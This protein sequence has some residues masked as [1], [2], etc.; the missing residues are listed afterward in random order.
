MSR[1]DA[2]NWTW[3][4]SGDEVFPAMLAAIGQARQSICLESYMYAAGQLG[5]AFREALIAA[6]QRG[7]NVRVLVDAIGSLELPDSYLEPLRAVGGEVRVF[8][9]LA[10]RRMSIRDH[11]KL[12]VCDQSVAFVGGFNISDDYQGDGIERGWRDVGARFEGGLV[13][14][15][16][17]SF[18][19]MFALAD[20]LHKRPVRLQ[21]ARQK[22]VVS[23]ANVQLLLSG[24]G[25]GR[26][27]IRRALLADLRRARRVQIAVPYFIPSWGLRRQLA[28]AARRGG[29]VQLLLP[30]KCDVTLAQLA[31]R[32]LYRGLLRAGVEIYEYQPQVLHAKLYVLD[33][34]V[35]VGSSNLDPRSLTINYEL[36]VRRQDASEAARAREIF[37]DSLAH[38]RR[39]EREEL[40]RNSTLWLRMK[41][42]FAYWLLVRVDPHVARKQWRSLPE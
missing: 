8:N 2:T 20:F 37:A 35:Y 16:A 1:L 34:A 9:P 21:R 27:P 24:P 30:G 26:S 28:R 40:R 12:L 42:Y 23:E 10:L 5:A 33:D 31:G 25:R 6:R 29:L 41:E 39:I 38:S 7:V 19:E 22:R 15:L 11:R 32:S 3:M 17:A 36:L 13:D 14:E 4:R 18:E